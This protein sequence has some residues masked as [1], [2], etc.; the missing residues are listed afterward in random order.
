[1]QPPFYISP[2]SYQTNLMVYGSGTYRVSD[3][4][5]IGVPLTLVVGASNYWPGAGYLAVLT[6]RASMGAG[7]EGLYLMITVWRN[8]RATCFSKGR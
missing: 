1:M 3:F 7:V 4:V 5:R 8:S 6:G 2:H